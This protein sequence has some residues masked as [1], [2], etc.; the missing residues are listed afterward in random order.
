MCAEPISD[1]PHYI[2]VEETNLLKSMANLGEDFFLIHNLEM[3]FRNCTSLKPIDD[4]SLKIPIFLYLVVTNEIYNVFASYLRL[5]KSLSFRCLRVA[6][7][8]TLTAYYLIKKPEKLDIYLCQL[9]EEVDKGKEKE[10]KKIFLNIKRT[11]NGSID[12]FPYAKGLIDIHEFCSIYSHSDALGVLHKYSEDKEKGVLEAKYFDYEKDFDDYN[13]W[14]ANMLLSYFNIFIV[15]W[16]EM[17]K[18]RACDKAI[19]IEKNI[20][21]YRI[22]LK[23]FSDKYP[24]ENR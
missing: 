22:N 17:F 6:I 11:I 18:F 19:A 1:F 9:E 5:H 12:D 21:E 15:F 24:F 7:D 2:G 4:K 16:N 3:L 8:C 14:L 13:K 10:W 23:V 20:N